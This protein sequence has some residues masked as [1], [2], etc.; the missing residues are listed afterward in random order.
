MWCVWCVRCV[1]GVCGVCGCPCEIGMIPSDSC[2]AHSCGERDRREITNIQ[3][4][5][6]WSTPDS[7]AVIAVMSTHKHTHITRTHH[8]HTS[9]THTHV[10]RTLPTAHYHTHRHTTDAHTS[11]GRSIHTR[12]HPSAHPPTPQHHTDT[13]THTPAH[14]HTHT[15]AHPAERLCGSCKEAVF[16]VAIFLHHGVL[17]GKSRDINPDRI[18][19]S[20]RSSLT[21]PGFTP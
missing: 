8:L 11:P 10:T 14:H 19:S 13:H 16:G 1:C 2:L 21:K 5:C 7:G 12:S 3:T 6:A 18:A 4:H 17:V 15:H 20:Y 9:H